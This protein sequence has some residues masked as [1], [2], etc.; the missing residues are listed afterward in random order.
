MN[1]TF[2]PTA[3]GT[4]LVDVEM[5]I[6]ERFLL[7]WNWKDDWDRPWTSKT[8]CIWFNSQTLNSY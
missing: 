4:E 6:L 5:L 1:S 8:W 3:S 7:L 2:Q